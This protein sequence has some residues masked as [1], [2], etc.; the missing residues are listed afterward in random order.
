MITTITSTE[1]GRLWWAAESRRVGTDWI[2]LLDA[3]QAALSQL[4]VIHVAVQSS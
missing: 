4:R 3:A 2:S 1:N